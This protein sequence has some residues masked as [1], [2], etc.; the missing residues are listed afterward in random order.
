MSLMKII[1]ELKRLL[2][3]AEIRSN[4]I[5]EDGRYPYETDIARAK[6]AVAAYT[7]CIFRLEQ[8]LD[9]E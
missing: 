4:V 9:V 7:Y 6:G 1:A 3:D 5:C 2:R 8:F